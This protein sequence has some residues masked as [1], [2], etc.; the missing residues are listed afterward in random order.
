[1]S[2]RRKVVASIGAVLL[3]TLAC[4]GGG[5]AGNDGMGGTGGTGGEPVQFIDADGN[6][7]SSRDLASAGCPSTFEV[8]EPRE[9][10]LPS[11]KGAC[12][13]WLATEDF[14]TPSLGCT[15]DP[16]SGEL[17]GAVLGSDV[18]EYCNEQSRYL[19]LGDGHHGCSFDDSRP[20][21]D[22]PLAR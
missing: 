19:I 15:Y 21:S 20:G 4:A 6:C 12:G 14:C 10:G 7:R 3:A 17:V 18:L 16:K 2:S 13:P 11:C 8:A 5:S 9:C 1:M 22:C